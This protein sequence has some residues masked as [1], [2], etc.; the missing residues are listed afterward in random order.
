MDIF[1]RKIDANFRLPGIEHFI[2]SDSRENICKT[3]VKSN[4][5]M[6]ELIDNIMGAYVNN[7]A[8]MDLEYYIYLFVKKYAAYPAEQAILYAVLQQAGFFSSAD[9]WKTLTEFIRPEATV[10]QN[11]RALADGLNNNPSNYVKKYKKIEQNGESLSFLRDKIDDNDAGYEWYYLS[12][13]EM[14]QLLFGHLPALSSTDYTQVEKNISNLN[15]EQTQNTNFAELLE[16]LQ[17]SQLG[18]KVRTVIQTFQSCNPKMSL[19][20]KLGFI[21][22]CSTIKE[23]L[24]IKNFS[25]LGNIFD[26]IRAISEFCNVLIATLPEEFRTGI[27]TVD[28]TSIGLEEDVHDLIDQTSDLIN[29]T[30]QLLINS[31]KS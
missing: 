13:L 19:D 17:Q 27:E 16:Y 25:T 8:T 18:E 11:Q 9:G 26:Y 22:E 7:G 23:K 2:G 24:D 6:R 28:L 14:V 15:E 4:L 20:Q 3:L 1:E 12:S 29:R 10:D 5:S 31:T 21:K 30:H